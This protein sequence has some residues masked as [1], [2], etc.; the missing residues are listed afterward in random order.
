[1]NDKPVIPQERNSMKQF[2]L[3]LLMM[4]GIL[5][6]ACNSATTGTPMVSTNNNL[7]IET[8]L[9][10]GTLKLSGSAQDVTLEQAKDLVLYW[11]VY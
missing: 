8:Q 4:A 1:M 11:Q 3:S 9:A 5:L 7:P 2:T 10:V 6:T